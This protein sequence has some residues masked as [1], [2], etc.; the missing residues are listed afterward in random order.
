MNSTIQLFKTRNIKS[1]SNIC[2]P[3]KNIISY[4]KIPIQI[5]I[6]IY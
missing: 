5:N 2:F 6:N 3:V 1:N 4:T